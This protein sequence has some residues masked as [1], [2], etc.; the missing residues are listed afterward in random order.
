MVKGERT[1]G[2]KRLPRA[3]R[4]RQLLDT[5]RRMVHDEGTEAIT[6]ARVA[7]EAGVSKP[8]A[9]RHFLSREGLLAALYRDFEDSQTRMLHAALATAP[10]TLEDVARVVAEAFIGCAVAAGPEV[11]PITAAL[12]GSAELEAVLSQCRRRHRLELRRAFAPFSELDDDDGE[13]LLTALLGAADTLAQAAAQGSIA[14]ER[15]TTALYRLIK[16]SLAA[17]RQEN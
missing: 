6:L 8:I 15:A 14:Q 4:G 7:E 12:S 1:T 2:A 9:Y 10:A 5:A 13:A 17:R 16:D 3:E 11:G